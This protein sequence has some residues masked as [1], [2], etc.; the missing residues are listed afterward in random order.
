MFGCGNNKN[1]RLISN[2][3]KSKVKEITEVKTQERVKNIF[4]STNSALITE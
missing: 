4:A 3:K 1:G 2:F